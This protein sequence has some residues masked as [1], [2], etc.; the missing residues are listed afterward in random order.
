MPG[1]GHGGAGQGDSEVYEEVTGTGSMEYQG[2]SGR[3]DEADDE[4]QGGE[5]YDNGHFE[6]NDDEDETSERPAD[7]M[8]AEDMAQHGE[9]HHRSAA[10]V[11]TGLSNSSDD[12]VDIRGGGDHMHTDGVVV[13]SID[14]E[15]EPSGERV[16]GMGNGMEE[17]VPLTIGPK[18]G[19]VRVWKDVPYNVKVAQDDL[20]NGYTE[21]EEEGAS[22]NDTGLDTHGGLSDTRHGER[23]VSDSHSHRGN[24]F[25]DSSDLSD[26]HSSEEFN[27]KH[28]SRWN[29]FNGE[30]DHKIATEELQHYYG[31]T[32]DLSHHVEGIVKTLSSSLEKTMT[33]ART[34]AKGARKYRDTLRDLS[35]GIKQFN[36]AAGEFRTRTRKRHSE[37]TNKIQANLMGPVDVPVGGA[38]VNAE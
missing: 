32:R 25:D 27:H 31:K 28:D 2:G 4:L 9:S 6:E 37:W 3:Y 11:D 26:D 38:G 17:R 1:I 22:R 5:I 18:G 24:G 30:G 33:N 35:L 8:E 10:L 36:E 23:Q 15:G 29:H 34:A 19:I 14:G 12:G 16:E 7:E 21:S 13:E 20:N